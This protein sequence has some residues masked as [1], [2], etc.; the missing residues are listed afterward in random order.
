M[1]AGARARGVLALLSMAAF[2]VALSSLGG[3][4]APPP[5]VLTLPEPTGPRTIILAIHR[6]AASGPMFRLIVSL[7]P[8]ELDPVRSVLRL[9]DRRVA[10]VVPPGWPTVLVDGAGRLEPHAL[11]LAPPQGEELL[12]H[13]RFEWIRDRLATMD[14]SLDMFLRQ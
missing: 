11:L 5:D 9:R 6:D 8:A 4:A 12:R 13:A 2:G 7:V 14:R 3:L 1:K 10:C